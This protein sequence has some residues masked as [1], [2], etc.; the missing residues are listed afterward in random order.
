MPII[1]GLPFL[2]NHNVICDYAKRKCSIKIDEKEYNLL[3]PGL[4][5]LAIPD[6]LAS[7]QQRIKELTNQEDLK[8][9]E[10]TLRTE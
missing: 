9:R 8:Q 10:S 7:V 4:N 2:T 3:M 5:T 1:L 6:T